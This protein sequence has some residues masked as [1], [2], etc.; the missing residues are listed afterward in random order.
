MNNNNNVNSPF[1]KFQSP[2]KITSNEKQQVKPFNLK[3]SSEKLYDPFSLG[4]TTGRKL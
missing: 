2:N 3:N 1:N 4:N